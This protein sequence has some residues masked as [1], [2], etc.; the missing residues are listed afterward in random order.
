MF[1]HK[2]YEMSEECW[3]CRKKQ[4]IANYSGNTTPSVH[5][6]YAM[7][8]IFGTYFW[9][10]NYFLD[11]RIYFFNEIFVSGLYFLN[12]KFLNL[13]F[14]KKMIG[15]KFKLVCCRKNFLLL[16]IP[17]HPKSHINDLEN[18]I[19]LNKGEVWMFLLYPQNSS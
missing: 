14:S 4:L 2:V 1:S 8:W 13:K 15:C 19:H 6:W 3:K 18:K 12:Y 10:R 11:I 9:F 7:I 5:W 16:S 17:N